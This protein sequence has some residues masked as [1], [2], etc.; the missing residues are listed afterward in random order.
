MDIIESMVRDNLKNILTY[1]PVEPISLISRKFGIP[2]DNELNPN[3]HIPSPFS[4]LSWLIL[5]IETKY[6]IIVILYS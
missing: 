5:Y 3:P 4:L 6:S 2:L 1:E